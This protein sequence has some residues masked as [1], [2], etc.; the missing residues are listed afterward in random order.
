M[1]SLLY[2]NSRTDWLLHIFFGAKF[3]SSRCCVLWEEQARKSLCHSLS[4]VVVTSNEHPTPLTLTR[5]MHSLRCQK[6]GKIWPTPEMGRVGNIWNCLPDNLNTGD[7]TLKCA[8]IPENL[9]LAIGREKI[10]ISDSFAKIHNPF[11][12]I[13]TYTMSRNNAM[14]WE[15]NLLI[16]KIYSTSQD[17]VIKKKPFTRHY[18]A[19][20]LSC[21]P[22]YPPISS[23]RH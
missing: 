14:Q 11:N 18:L 4:Q 17:F 20:L 5:P 22:I 7:L 15:L 19:Y 9:K 21:S 1:L 12:V 23:K 2:L 13:Q 3:L 16:L 10:H 8:N 6:R